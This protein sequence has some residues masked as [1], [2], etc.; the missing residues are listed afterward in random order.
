MRVAYPLNARYC[1]IRKTGLWCGILIA[2]IFLLGGSAEALI[3]GHCGT[4]CMSVQANA[5]KAHLASVVTFFTVGFLLGLLVL[6]RS[7]PV[8]YTRKILAL[9]LYA[10]PFLIAPT[11]VS[12]INPGKSPIAIYVICMSAALFV[13]CALTLTAPVR[14][15]S[16]FFATVFAA[17]D[18]PE[19]RPFTLVWLLTSILATWAVVVAW[20]LLLPEMTHYILVALFVSGVGDA[21]AEPIGYRFG[22]H[23]YTVGAIWTNQR[24]KRSFEGSA[25]V[26]MS[27]IVGV[28]L[29]HG[30]TPLGH[31][32][33]ELMLAL[34][35]I[36]PL[37]TLA[38]A[39]SPHTWDQPFIV[40]ACSVGAAII[41]LVPVL[42]QFSATIWS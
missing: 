26:F 11:W 15:R 17:I 2:A 42:V 18:R 33:G 10:A 1:V 36:P 35:L 21:L 32:V 25:C 19:D 27:A 9:T 4:A 29:L 34:L 31:G 6:K 5:L 38:E 30:A 41:A 3:P 16:S 40:A 28:L 23:T 13:F 8:A 12:V 37:A 7:W 39:K 22:R 20:V 24:Y 14:S